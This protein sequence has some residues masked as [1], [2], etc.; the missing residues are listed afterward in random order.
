MYRIVVALPYI[1]RD[2]SF[3]LWVHR[4][5]NIYGGFDPNVCHQ[6]PFNSDPGQNKFSGHI[7]KFV[8]AI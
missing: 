5:C 7:L 1:Y 8:W 4:L 3:D 2:W 6:I